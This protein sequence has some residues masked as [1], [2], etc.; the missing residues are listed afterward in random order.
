MRNAVARARATTV[1][2][3]GQPSFQANQIP[4]SGVSPM[5][6]LF[7]F[8]LAVVIEGCGPSGRACKDGKGGPMGGMP[9]AQVAVI[10]V[11]ARSLPASYEYTS[12]N[13]S[14]REVGG[15]RR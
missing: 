1:R 8:L 6:F 4:R 15:G 10:T 13:I 12:Q 9:P 3:D 11:E 2:S 5:R 14:S 7:P